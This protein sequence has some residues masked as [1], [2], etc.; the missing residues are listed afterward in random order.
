M[1]DIETLGKR[2][3][4]A[5]LSIGAVYFDP[6]SDVLGDEFYTNIRVRE[7]FTL[8]LHSDPSTVKWW[9][10]DAGQEARDAL[11]TEPRLVI[12][13]AAEAF[14]KFAKRGKYFWA[15]D[16]DFDCVILDEVFR[17]LEMKAPWKY[18]NKRSCRTIYHLADVKPIRTEGV[19]HNALD[20]AIQ[21]AKAVQHATRELY[22]LPG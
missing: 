14:Y 6:A 20:D 2:A 19:H 21:Q 3:G 16:P 15:N 10:E 4:C 8:G 17:I 13:D 12:Q 5:V 7:Q 18:Y 22:G 9:V 1:L 11:K